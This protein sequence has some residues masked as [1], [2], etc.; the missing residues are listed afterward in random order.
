[1]SLIS[2]VIPIHNVEPYLRTCL[3]SV[4][5]QTA[6]DL[7]VIMV[8]DGSTDGSAAIA[9]EFAVADPRFRLLSQPN[10]GLG[11]ARNTGADAATGEFLAFV[12]SDDVLPRNAY[13]LLLGSLEKTGSDFATGNVHRLTSIGT[14]QARFLARVFQK[15]RPK[16]HITKFRPLLA[17]RIVPNKLWRRSFWDAQGLRF[18]EG[19]AHEDIPVVLPA[20]FAARSVDVIAEPVYLYRIREG[21]DLTAQSITQRRMEQSVLLDRIAAITH[22]RD[23]LARNGPRKARRWYEQSVVGADLMYFLD[24]L[25]GADDEFRALFLDRVNAFLDGAGR[26]VFDELVAINR[27]KWHLVRRRLMPELVEVLYFH[28]EKLRDTPPVRVGR[29]WY[30]DYPYRTDDGLRIPKSVYRLDKELPAR[31][32]V[33]TLRWDGDKL[34]VEGYMF[35]SGIGAPHPDSQRVTVTLLR[36]GPLRAIRQRVSAVRLKTVPAHRPDATASSRQALCDLEWSGFAAALNP[37]RLRRLGRWRP[38]TWQLY[39][40]VRAGDL[41]RRSVKFRLDG[42]RPVRAVD[43][44]MSG[45]VLVKATPTEDG[46]IDVE[47]R[48]RWARILSHRLSDGVAELSGEVRAPAGVK[49]ALRLVRPGASGRLEYPVTVEEGRSP[50]AFDVRVPLADLDGQLGAET[51]RDAEAVWDLYMHDGRRLRVTL[52]DD[53]PE[54]LWSHEDREFSLFRTQRGEAA[55]VARRPHPVI[56]DARWTEGGELELRGKVGDPHK[57]YELV[58]HSPGR[59]EEHAFPF[60]LDTGSGRFEAKPTPGRVSTLAGELPLRE[61]TWEIYAR[62]VGESMVPLVLAQELYGHLPLQAVVG[63]KPFVLGMTPEQHA[64]LFAQ[65][66]LDTHERGLFQQRRLRETAYARCR[67][68]TLRDT[69]VY[70]SFSGRQ[71]SDSP[72]AIHEELVRRG[73]TLE[74]LWVVRDGMCRV[75]PSAKVVRHRSQEYYEALA[76]ARFVVSNDHFPEWFMRRPDQVCLQTWHGTPLKRLGLDVPENRRNIRRAKRRWS[77]QAA[78]WQY[79][80]SPNRFSTPI[81]RRAYAVEG[82]LLET[83]YP[84]DD[85]LAGPDRDAATKRLRERLALPAGARVILYAPTFRDNVVDSRG[86][87]RLDLRLDLDRL[88]EAI[89]R[90]SVLLFR[91]HH[92]VHDVVPATANGFV[93]D[94][95]AYPDGTELLLAADVL[96]TDYSSVMFDFGNTR[97]PM[98]FFTYDLDAYQD[99]IRGFYFDFAEKAPG[100]LLRTTDELA[101]ALNDVESIQSQYAERYSEFVSTFCELDDGQAAARVVDRVFSA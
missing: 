93:R 25:D 36:E 94:V 100:P 22:V 79:L 50:A 90:D 27:L 30:G 71:Y 1:M 77:E 85:V 88:H 59:L 72:R 87:Y 10:G 82:E 89:G 60:D 5:R 32:Y 52:A 63:H 69:V 28:R 11:N 66:D 47:V 67:G 17:D 26:H 42:T 19:V 57:R 54:A 83:G 78:N 41:T 18:P 70:A 56:T 23:Y 14:N 75:P 46:E 39:V 38:G 61:G 51:E 34:V 40:T 45:G 65:R 58:L 97:R 15:T 3:E 74:H 6:G 76:R 44:P 55:L 7:E 101:S 4:A 43:R 53:V 98:L 86:R 9:E 37:R 64:V 92:Y 62:A 29:H 81:L 13:E 20:Q 80:V 49:L 31:P 12:D 99:Q 68:E 21:I 8:D 95:S 2:V 16:T 24:V 33:D 84:R 96:V 48:D 73:A 91:K 35:I